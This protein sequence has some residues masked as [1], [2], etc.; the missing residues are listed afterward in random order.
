MV[1]VFGYTFWLEYWELSVTP[2]GGRVVELSVM[3][4][5]FGIGSCRSVGF[6]T[7]TLSFFRSQLTQSPF[8]L[9]L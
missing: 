8:Y 7:R 5:G 1:G 4:P 6:D 3:S 2:S 9:C